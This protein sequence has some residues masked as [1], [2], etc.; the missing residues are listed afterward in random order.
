MAR[1][2]KEAEVAAVEVKTE[3]VKTEEVKVEAANAET[4]EPAKDEVKTE[5]A[6]AEAETTEATSRKDQLHEE[7]KELV[8]K[9]NEAYGY[10]EYKRMQELDTEIA[11]KVEEYTGI[12]ERECFEEILNEE[13]PMKA[14]AERVRYAT[15]KVRD[16][17][18]DKVTT[19]VVEASSN[20]IDPLKLHKKA[21]EGI[22][23]DKNWHFMI[24]KLNMLL[25]CRRAIELGLNPRE[26]KN[27]YSMSEE[28]CKI[29]MLMDGTSPDKFDKNAADEILKQDVQKVVNAMLGEGYEVTD[30]M[31]N[32]LLMIYQKKNNRKSLSVSCANH[33]N[34]RIYLLDIC[35]A[36]VTGNEFS[37]IYKVKK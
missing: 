33:R 21:K 20:Q 14:A 18:E 5:E 16:V 3:E 27:T 24:E 23:A 31:I 2:K 19:R 34:M 36:C 28:A 13:N 10:R 4:T 35:H 25:T 15:I 1:R 12:S 26:I 37:V 32:Y 6:A 30:V 11:D 22:G 9:Y 29:E 8:E 7:I 17:T